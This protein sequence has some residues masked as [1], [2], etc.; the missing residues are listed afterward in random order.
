MYS[1]MCLS[2]IAGRIHTGLFKTGLAQRLVT[3]FAAP[4]G[5]YAYDLQHNLG[6]PARQIRVCRLGVDVEHFTPS[7]REPWTPGDDLVVGM[8]SRL[9]QVKGVDIAVEA[10][11]KLGAESGI[12][13]VIVG[14]GSMREAL[15]ALAKATAPGQVAPHVE[16]RGRRDDVREVLSEFDLYLQTSR[17][18]NLGLSAL[19][20][21]AAGVPLAIVARDADEVEMALDTLVGDDAG[22]VV[23]ADPGDLG[24]WLQDFRESA[25]GKLEGWRAG[26]RRTA[27]DHYDWE[28]HVDAVESAY[29]EAVGA[30]GS[31]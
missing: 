18:P 27:E 10:V 9:E 5:Y 29:A 24:H 23:P 25:G 1:P 22:A 2:G 14:D 30:D 21:L 6:V 17:S 15:E 12:R 26:A 7:P 19:E 11:S 4:S 16:F 31:A 8:C 28:H 13:L 20:A 3:L